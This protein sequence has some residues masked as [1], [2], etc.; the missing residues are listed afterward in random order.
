[1]D[2]RGKKQHQK[3]IGF[4]GSLRT[5]FFITKRIDQNNIK[6]LLDNW[7]IVC[8]NKTAVDQTQSDRKS[9]KQ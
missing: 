1:M 9:A 2:P 3:A 8:Y 7:L 5:Y 6:M 4:R